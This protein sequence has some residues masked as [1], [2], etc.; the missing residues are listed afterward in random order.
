MPQNN[1]NTVTAIA[2]RTVCKH[3]ANNNPH[4]CFVAIHCDTKAIVVECLDYDH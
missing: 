2:D 3:D 1:C 4:K